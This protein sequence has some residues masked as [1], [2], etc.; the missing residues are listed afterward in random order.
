VHLCGTLE[1]I[2]RPFAVYFNKVSAV[3]NELARRNRVV[4][5]SGRSVYDKL[6]VD[7]RQ[8]VQFTSVREFEVRERA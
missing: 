1:A 3:A 5:K 8:G 7:R 2:Q 4:N 6:A